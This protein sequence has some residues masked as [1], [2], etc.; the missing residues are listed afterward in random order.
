MLNNVVAHFTNGRIV[1][2]TSLD[3]DVGK[4]MCHVRTESEGTVPVELKDL[5]ALYF[6]KDLSG[7]PGYREHQDPQDGDVRIR[8]SRMI[9]IRFSDGEEMGG[10]TNRYPPTRPF[11]FVLPMDSKSNNIRILVNKGAIASITERD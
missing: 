7:N 10:L 4:P 2:G 6:V 11:F 8:G 9:E 3:V 5:K 1:K